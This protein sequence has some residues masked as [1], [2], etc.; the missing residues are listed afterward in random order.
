MIRGVLMTG[1]EEECGLNVL[2]V[3]L[4]K[5]YARSHLYSISSLYSPVNIEGHKLT[6]IACLVGGRNIRSD[7]RLKM[8]EGRKVVGLDMWPQYAC[9]K[10][11]MGVL[12]GP[13]GG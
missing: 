10:K 3:W 8:V 12:R 5:L 7:E 4:L 13:Q 1:I 11:V 6:L 2:V 9:R